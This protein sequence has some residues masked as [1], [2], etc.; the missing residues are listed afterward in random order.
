MIRFSHVHK[1]FART[2]AA[3]QDVSFQVN[4][5]EFVFITGPSGA[6]KSTIL[7]LC[8][9]EERPTE[10]EVKVHGISSATYGPADV[11]KLRRRLG[12]V[13]QD[14]RLLED[15]NV[16]S[17]VAFA[18]EVTGMPTAQIGPRVSRLLA[19]VGLAAKA[20]ALPHELS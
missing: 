13:F 10:G 12:I 2:G 6:G 15:R 5:G 3:L 17:N 11:P 9:F 4:K 1:R 19:Q 8:F 14:F 20:T 18:L 16:E 7:K